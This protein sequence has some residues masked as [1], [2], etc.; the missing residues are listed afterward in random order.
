MVQIAVDYNAGIDIHL[1]EGGETGLKAIRRLADLT[2][3]AGSQGKVTIRHAFSL[4]S[5]TAG[6]DVEMENRLASLGISLASQL[7]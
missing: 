5:L 6:A 3:E 7:V 4:A 1:H 2:E